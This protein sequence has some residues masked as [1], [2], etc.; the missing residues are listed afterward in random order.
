VPG[1]S[2][3][4]RLTVVQAEKE[5]MHKQGSEP[6]IAEDFFFPLSD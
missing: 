1:G 4:Q 3:A 2:R 6:E 5:W